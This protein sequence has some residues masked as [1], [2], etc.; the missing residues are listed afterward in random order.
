VI[1]EKTVCGFHVGILRERLIP[2]ATIANAS[3]PAEATEMKK[4]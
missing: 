1:V 4:T 3:Q 2:A